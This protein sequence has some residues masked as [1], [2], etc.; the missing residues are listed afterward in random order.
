[1]FNFIWGIVIMDWLKS[2][3]FGFCGGNIVNF[4]FD[5]CVEF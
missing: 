1:M 5:S 2:F 3:F 4:I